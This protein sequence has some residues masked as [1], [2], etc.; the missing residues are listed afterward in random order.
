MRLLRVIVILLILAIGGLSG[1]A[2][3]GDMDAAP[4]EMRVPVQLDLGAAAPAQEDTDVIAP[5]EVDAEGQD[6][7]QPDAGNLD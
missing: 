3:L 5:I 6:A 2:Y 1:Y 4:K 7:A